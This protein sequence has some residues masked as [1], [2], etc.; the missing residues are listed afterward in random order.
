MLRL[1][2]LGQ[3]TTSLSGGFP[4]APTYDILARK[5]PIAPWPYFELVVIEIWIIKH[6]DIFI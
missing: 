5:V 2:A 3:H 4:I 1:S 6:K